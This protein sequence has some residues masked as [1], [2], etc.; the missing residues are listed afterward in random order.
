MFS[1]RARLKVLFWLGLSLIRFKMAKNV[2]S[3]LL[4]V[5]IQPKHHTEKESL[6]IRLSSLFQFRSSSLPGYILLNWLFDITA[7]KFSGNS[8]SKLIL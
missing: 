7:L 8:R 5:G 1:S 4:D 2:E 6:N 3:T